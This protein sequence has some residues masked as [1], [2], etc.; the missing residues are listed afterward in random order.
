PPQRLSLEA[1]LVNATYDTQEDDEEEIVEQDDDEEEENGLEIEE[2]DDAEIEYFN[3]SSRD[4][5]EEDN[6]P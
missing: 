2:V 4:E 6:A 3:Y 1:P 5:S